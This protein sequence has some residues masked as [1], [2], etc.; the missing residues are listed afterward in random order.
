MPP[1]PPSPPP[2]SL[3]PRGRG[4]KLSGVTRFTRD[5]WGHRNYSELFFYFIFSFK[6]KETIHEYI[7]HSWLYS[8]CVRGALIC[9]ARARLLADVSKNYFR[10]ALQPWAV[11]TLGRKWGKKWKNKRK[12][13]KKKEYN[14]LPSGF[15]FSSWCNLNVSPPPCLCRR[16]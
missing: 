16:G 6:V 11:D 15:F 5:T 1:P 8:I 12:K 4:R 14:I 10:T 2:P 7:S 9:F 3:E 13:V